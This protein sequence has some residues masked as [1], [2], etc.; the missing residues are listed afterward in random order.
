MPFA[1]FPATAQDWPNRAVTLV[2]PFG[3]GS[4]SD[5]V[6]RIFAARWSEVLGQQVVVENIGGAGG[7]IGVG[8]VSK[9][10]RLTAI[11]SSWAASIP[12]P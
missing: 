5:V 1:A 8:R 6:G 3:P 7:T 10:D 12:S 11:S 9:A 4:A 2:V